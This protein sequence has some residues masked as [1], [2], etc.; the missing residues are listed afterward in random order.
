MILALNAVLSGMRTK[1]YSFPS[2]AT[3]LY[4]RKAVINSKEYVKEN[5]L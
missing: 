2:F 5:S 1:N 3:T 4:F